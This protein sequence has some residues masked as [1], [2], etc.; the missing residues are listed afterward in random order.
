MP[1]L[2]VHGPTRVF[3]LLVFSMLLIDCARSFGDAP[4]SI[5]PTANH[6]SALVGP[7]ATLEQALPSQRLDWENGTGSSYVI[8]AA[9]I[10]T[11]IFLLNQYDRRFVEPRE[12][13]RSSGSTID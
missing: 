4:P 12:E 13:Y 10:L 7:P 11:Y 5:D 8:P 9:E 3:L 1:G 6:Q 2:I